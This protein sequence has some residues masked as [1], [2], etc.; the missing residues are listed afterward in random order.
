MLGS[1]NLTSE[2]FLIRKLYQWVLK[3]ADHPQSY[4]I[5]AIFTFIEA[6]F[7]PIPNYP[8]LIAIC[9]SNPKKSIWASTISTVSSVTGGIFGYM[10]GHYL[11]QSTS[12]FIFKYLFS[13]QLYLMVAEKF[14]QNTFI[15]ILL[16]CFTPI[17]FKVFTITAGAA[18][19]PL[20]PFI[21]A[22]TIGRG[23]RFYLIGF[24]FYFFGEPVKAWIEKHFDRVIYFSA[25]IIFIAL[26]L[27]YFWR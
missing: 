9:V 10:V 1:L 8:L 11:W 24:L 12:A 2:L 17:P 15:A 4:L 19:V 16:A 25:V 18:N 6:S 26:V 27:Y 23:F 5:L 20:I 13:E 21:V 3:W 14:Q 7:F 22:A